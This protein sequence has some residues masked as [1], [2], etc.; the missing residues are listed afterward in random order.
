VILT[1]ATVGYLGAQSALYALALVSGVKAWQILRTWDFNK[2]TK[3]QYANEKNA[4]LVSTVIIFLLFF[5]ALLAIFLIYL[6]DS[7]TPFIRAAMCGVGVLNATIL[8]W[9]LIFLKMALIALF[10]LWLKS[11]LKD[12][13]A[14]DYPLI[15][16]KFR[17]FLIILFLMSIELLFDYIMIFSLETQKVVSC[18]SVTFSAQ[19]ELAGFISLERSFV[20]VVF[21]ITALFYL[22][23]GV[24]SFFYKKAQPFFGVFAIFYLIVGLFFVVYTVSPYVYELPTHTCPFCIIQKEYFYIGYLFYLFLFMSGFYGIKRGFSKLFLKENGKKDIILSLIFGLIF[25]ALSLLYTFG[26]YIKNGVW[27]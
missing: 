15:K 19:N 10:G 8:G 26:Y 20:G 5:K 22:L 18:C 11:D 25:I 4:Y 17:F 6:I 13:E 27:L 2:S 14:L 1:S 23:L 12:K 16:F 7:L 21:F 3:E 9:E 24:A